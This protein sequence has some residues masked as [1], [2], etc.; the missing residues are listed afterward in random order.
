MDKRELARFDPVVFDEAVV[1]ADENAAAG[2]GLSCRRL[3]SGAGHDAQMLARVCP[4]AMVFV[5][6]V[7]GIS[8]NPT[9]YTAP[10][11][12]EAGANVLLDVISDLA[13]LDVPSGVPADVTTAEG[14]GA[15]PT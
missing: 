15:E 14:A 8:H 7:G 10:H 6:S 5:P 9:E 4:T 12:L 3:P 2:R 13:G 11:D 1:S